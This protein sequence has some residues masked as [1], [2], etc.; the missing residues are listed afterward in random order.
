MAAVIHIIIYSKPSVHPPSALTW[1]VTVT[2]NLIISLS[3][4]WVAY[5]CTCE[6]STSERREEFRSKFEFPGFEPL[7]I[8]ARCK[9]E[10]ETNSE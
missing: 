1:E 9:E 4:A 6:H 2:L 10:H 3:N 7:H 8:T 5:I